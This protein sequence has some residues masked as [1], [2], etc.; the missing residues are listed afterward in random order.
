MPHDTCMNSF[1]TAAAALLLASGPAMADMERPQHIGTLAAA[2]TGAPSGGASAT[3]DNAKGGPGESHDAATASS[4]KGGSMSKGDRAMMQE[5]AMSNMSEIAAAKLAL[6]KAPN[7]EVKNY[8]QKMIDDHTPAMNELQAFAKSK[9][10]V[11]PKEPDAQHKAAMKKL[12][13]QSPENFGMAYMKQAGVTDHRN[14]L[15][16]LTRIS[17]GADDAEFKG[18]AEKMLPVVEKHL[19]M[20]EMAAGIK[21]KSQPRD[22]QK[23]APG[24]R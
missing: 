14:T 18:M 7:D 19:Q 1:W 17:K 2:H 10:V 12:E 6:S 11:L 20:G 13:G 16:L 21:G 5:L 23:D 4:G 22:M 24:V 9:G 8:A 3:A 15:R